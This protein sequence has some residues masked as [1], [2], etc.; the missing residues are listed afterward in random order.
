[1]SSGR[2]TRLTAAG[3]C[4][5]AP[6]SARFPARDGVPRAIAVSGKHGV[7]LLAT[8][9]LWIDMV[10]GYRRAMWAAN[11]AFISDAAA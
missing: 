5:Y 1:M 10:V 9:A 11:D 4:P 2:T 8:P 7:T 6:A 3:T